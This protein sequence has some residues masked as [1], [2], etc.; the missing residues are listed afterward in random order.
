MHFKELKSFEQRCT[1][2][3]L[4][5]TRFPERIPVILQRRRELAP[6]IDKHKFMTPKSLTCA[7]FM[8]VARKRMVVQSSQAL[9]FFVGNG[10]L[11]TGTETL[12][13][14][15]KRY[16]DEDGF[17]YVIYDIENTFG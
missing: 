1:E 10:V 2:S 13:N 3:D 15:A 8:F 11:V 17:L 14:M 16:G 7:Q 6:E 12:E 9:F 5:K 4:M